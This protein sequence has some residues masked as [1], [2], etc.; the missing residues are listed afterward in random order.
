VTTPIAD[1]APPDWVFVS[2]TGAGPITAPSSSVIGRYAYAIYDEGGLLDAN[3]AG[4]P[5]N[6]T[7]AQYGRKGVSA[8]ADLTV[9]GLSSPGSVDNIVGWRNC[10]SAKPGSNFPTFSFTTAQANDYV[11]SVL[12][13]TNGFLTVLATRSN[14]TDNVWVSGSGGS[15]AAKRTDQMFPDRQTLIKFRASSGFNANALQYLGTFSRELNAPS[16]KPSTPAGSTIDYANLAT[17]PT[18]ETSTAINRDLLS[19]RVNSSFTRFDGTSAIVGEPLIER[20]FPLSR[21]AWITYKGP[22]AAVYAANSS[23]PVIVQLLANNVSLQTI[24]LGTAA[25]IQTCFGLIWVPPVST[26]PTTGRW[27]YVGASG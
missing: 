7:P 23:D 3:V 13:N 18:P 16:W 12:S 2:N 11:N 17:I 14:G 4:Y 10:A 19:V 22:S 8:F 25:N 6:T 21:L 27:N 5:N 26:D 20:R 9:L 1:F 24:Q 15:N